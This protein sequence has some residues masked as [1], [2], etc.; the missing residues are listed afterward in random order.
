MHRFALTTIAAL[1]LAPAAH[2]APSE[3]I[4]VGGA[5]AFAFEGPAKFGINTT[6]EAGPPVCQ[7]PIPSGACHEVLIKF[8]KAGTIQL[9]TEFDAN[10]DIDT[11]LYKSDA[12]GTRGETAADGTGFLGE[13]ETISAGAGAGEYL[14]FQANY[15]FA[16][17]QGFSV[18]GTFEGDAPAAPAVN[19]LPT[20][21]IKKASKSAISGTAADPDGT[22]S[23]VEVSILKKSGSKCAEMKAN[24]SFGKAG[25]C[26]ASKPLVAKGTSAWSFKPKKA[27]GK[28]SY[29]ILARAT[30]AAGGAQAAFT[31]KTLKVS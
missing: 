9:V 16:A 31:R 29:I 15:Y 17:N 10:T 4:E 14:L 20:A 27:L 24:G 3:T 22:V 23:K 11:A 2:A 26:E 7:D 5:A 28:G 25:K 19:Q 13:A 6:S 21:T 30:D 1:A 8:N 12:S 18:K